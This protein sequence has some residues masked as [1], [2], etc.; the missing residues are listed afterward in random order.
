[1]LAL[2]LAY[3]HDE[4]TTLSGFEPRP[5]GGNSQPLRV[6]RDFGSGEVF[7]LAP[8]VEYNWNSRMGVIVGAIFT[9]AGRNAS[10]NVIPVAAINM[11]F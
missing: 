4:R 2:D 11:V 9:A 3:E 8:A 7:T 6:D 5:P 10:A 1:M